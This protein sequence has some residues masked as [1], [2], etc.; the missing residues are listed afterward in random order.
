MKRSKTHT[1][2]TE[3][4]LDALEEHLAGTLKPITPPTELVARMRDRLRFPQTE[5]IVSRL[6]NWKRLIW[7]YVGVMSSFLVVVTV[8]RA[9]YYFISRK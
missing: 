9:F 8:A 4:D 7:I 2:E 1:A 5:E 6:G 3:E